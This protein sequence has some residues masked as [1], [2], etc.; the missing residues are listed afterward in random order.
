MKNLRIKNS[1]EI[2]ILV[3]EEQEEESFSFFSSEN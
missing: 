2:Q 3:S 1:K